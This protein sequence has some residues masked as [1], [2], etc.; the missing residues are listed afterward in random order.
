MKKE[1]HFQTRRVVEH[2][3]LT[4]T[5]IGMIVATIFCILVVGSVVVYRHYYP[6]PPKATTEVVVAT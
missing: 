6:T 3:D 4:A 2:Y 1:E 5:D